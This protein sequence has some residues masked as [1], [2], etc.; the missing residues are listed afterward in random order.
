MNVKDYKNAVAELG[1][2]VDKCNLPANLHHPR[3]TCG[4]GQRSSDWLVVPLCKTHHQDGGYGVALHA[5]Q[6]TW[7]KNF[8]TEQEMLAKTIKKMV[9]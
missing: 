2:I 9:S 5:G 6:A 4:M 1:C 7:E 8:M 3:F